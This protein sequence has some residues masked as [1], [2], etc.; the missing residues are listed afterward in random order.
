MANLFYA[1][2]LPPNP[3]SDVNTDRPQPVSVKRRKTKSGFKSV[4]GSTSEKIQLPTIPPI[5]DLY[6]DNGNTSTPENSREK[7]TKRKK[8]KKIETIDKSQRVSELKVSSETDGFDKRSPEIVDEYQVKKKSK[9]SRD[10][11]YK[12]FRAENI[13]SINAEDDNFQSGAVQPQAYLTDDKNSKDLTI[14]NNSDKSISLSEELTRQKDVVI[15]DELNENESPPPSPVVAQGLVPLPQPAQKINEDLKPEL[16]GLP[17]WMT[18]PDCIS[19]LDTTPLDTLPLDPSSLAVLKNKGYQQAFAIQ[20]AVI[21]SLLPGSD[22]HP[23]DICIS[24]A[25][26]SG[27]T[28]AYALPMVQCL[29]DKP[30]TRLRGLI[31][32]PTRELV[33]Q[34]RETLELCAT[35][36]ALKIGTA[37]GSKSLK[38]EQSLLVEKGQKYD[39]D[40]YRL[41]REKII[42]EDEELMDWDF[43]NLSDEGDESEGFMDYVVEYTSKVDILICTPGRLVD[44]IKSTKGFTLNHIQWLVV[45]EADRLLDESFQQWV[46]MITPALEYQAPLDPIEEQIQKTFHLSHQRT[47]RKIILSA[48]MTK[49]IDKIQSLKLRDPKLIVL[50]NLNQGLQ[51]LPERRHS[52]LQKKIELPPNLTEI[53]IPIKNTEDKPLYLVEVL[54]N[55]VDHERDLTKTNDSSSLSSE[56]RAESSQGL[57]SFSTSS[58]TKSVPKNIQPAKGSSK[59]SSSMFNSRAQPTHGVLIFTNNNENALRLA[60]LLTIVKPSWGPRIATLTKSTTNSTGRKSLSAFRNGKTSFLIA[61]DRASRGLDVPDLAQVIN[62][63]MPTSIVSYVHRVGRTARA[64]KDGIATTLVSHHEARWFWNEI[65]RSE[66]IVRAPEKKV[67]RKESKLEVSEE[68]RK[69]YAEALKKLGQEA[70]GERA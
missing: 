4:T 12:K 2:Y 11:S 56:E 55:G 37:F 59:G 33:V 1:R 34:A 49:E 51:E 29:R 69:A 35:G 14:S 17:I 5:S 47:V 57:N 19:S 70:R 43:D 40:A 18:H 36:S 62:Y 48:T 45:D 42:D 8:K 50:E 6:V 67:M 9:E 52:G 64:G 60:R 23:G 22:Y 39:P 3:A 25:T 66:T 27:K 58:S 54:E 7:L 63:D 41:E 28:L 10:K 30:L 16:S 15:E 38:E 24:A 44:H 31:V 26:G 68:E 46:E 61:S 20:K 13:K 53:A 21:S 32:V 65:A